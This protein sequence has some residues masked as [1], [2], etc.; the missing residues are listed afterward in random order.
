[1]VSPAAELPAIETLPGASAIPALSQ[2][3]AA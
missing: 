1:M 2:A 3:V